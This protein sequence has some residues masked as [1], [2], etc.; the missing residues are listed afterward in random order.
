MNKELET[1]QY[2]KLVAIQTHALNSFFLS[3]FV[4]S[5]LRGSIFKEMDNQ[6]QN[7]DSQFFLPFFPL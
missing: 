2:S 6:S 3:I 5:R 1:N 7:M 4:P